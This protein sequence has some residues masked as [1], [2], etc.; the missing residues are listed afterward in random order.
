VENIHPEKKRLDQAG[1][2]LIFLICQPRSGSTLLQYILAGHPRIHTLPEPWFML[3]LLYGHRSEGLAAEYDAGTAHQALLSYLSA[4][5]GGRRLYIESVRAAA[6]NMYKAALRESGKDLFLDKTPRYYLIVEDL[7]EMFPK[8]RFIFL[9]RNPLAVLASILQPFRGDWTALRRLDRMHD[10]VTAPRNIMRAA[11][12]GGR[13][14]VA[15]YES[16]V[17]NTD[18]TVSRM[19]EQLDIERTPSLATYTSFESELGDTKSVTT[20]RR[21]VT[22]YVDRWKQELNSDEK[23]DVAHS[24]LNE[25][26]EELL[27]WLGYPYRELSDQLGVARQTRKAGSRWAMLQTP[28]DE[29]R[30]WQRIRLS[31]VRS[32]HQRGAWRTILRGAYILV[33]GHAPRRHNPRDHIDRRPV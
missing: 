4:T 27:E 10:L 22:E 6:L 9:V 20:H 24:Y 11:N 31:F 19:L 3:H 8:A 12:S 5:E 14:S 2:N 26:G 25:L 21:P 13:F 17:M 23:R 33:V 16:L 30:W 15:R 18:A 7:R 28:D 29:L 32:R 1:E